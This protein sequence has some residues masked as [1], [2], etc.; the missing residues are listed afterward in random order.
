MLSSGRQADF[1]TLSGYPA[2]NPLAIREDFL[3]CETSEERVGP[4]HATEASERT[5][6]SYTY[7][8]GGPCL[9]VRWSQLGAHSFA[10]SAS[11]A[12]LRA[13]A[14]VS[15]CYLS[16]KELLPASNLGDSVFPQLH[17]L[18]CDDLCLFTRSLPDSMATE[19]LEN[20]PPHPPPA[21]MLCAPP[22]SQGPAAPSCSISRTWSRLLPRQPFCS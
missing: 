18:P 4:V 16:P 19:H 6:Q 2:P 12:V 22:P 5:S 7:G 14:R 17:F 10:R 8:T 20:L 1:A 15:F 21:E 9:L 13:Q 11:R 3:F